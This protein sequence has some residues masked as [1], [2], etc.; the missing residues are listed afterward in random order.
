[1]DKLSAVSNSLADHAVDQLRS[2]DNVTVMI[3]LITDPTKPWAPRGQRHP[4]SS[5]YW[6]SHDANEIGMGGERIQ[7]SSSRRYNDKGSSSQDTSS[8]RGDNEH[9]YDAYS[10]GSSTGKNGKK[11]SDAILISRL[12]S[13][14]DE[15]KTDQ[16]PSDSVFLRPAA[17]RDDCMQGGKGAERVAVSSTKEEKRGETRGEKRE[18]KKEAEDEDLMDFL[19]DDSNF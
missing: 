7:A 4:T 18:Q 11:K 9:T 17:R 8:S 10:S 16:H 3:I 12:N 15:K 19:M 1:M 14:G 6:L 5:S 2:L 13:G